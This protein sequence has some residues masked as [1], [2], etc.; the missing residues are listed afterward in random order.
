MCG[1]ARKADV[2]SPRPHGRS[3]ARADVRGAGAP[4]T[5]LARHA[6]TSGVGLGIQRCA[7]STSRPAT[8]RS[9]TRIARSWSS[10]TARSTTSASCVRDL[11]RAGHASGPQGDTEVIVHL[12]E[13]YGI[14]CV[15]HLHG[16]FAFALWDKRRA[17]PAA[18]PRPRRQ[19]AA[20]LLA[21]RRRAE[22]RLGAAARS[23]RIPRSRATLDPARARLLPAYGYVPAPLRD[24]PGG[25]ASCRRRTPWCWPTGGATIAR[26]WQLDY[27]PASSARHGPRELPR[28]D[29]RRDPGRDV[30]RRMIADVPLGA[31]LSGGIDS[32]AVVAAMAEASRTRSR[33]SRSA[34]STT[35]QRAA[36][37]PPGGRAVRH[38][39]PRVRGRAATRSTSCRRSSAT[40]ASRSPTPRRSRAST[41]PS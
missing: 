4:R 29:P 10:S 35:L 5:G 27:S 21:A 3:S 9:T 31:F 39:P 38:R 15:R 33:R 14:D 23:S 28:A 36:L 40:T 30:R 16:M 2:T 19:E 6:S 17:A 26:Y 34:S 32:S 8:S 7:W 25:V 37:R 41:S 22:L 11:Q 18:R 20:V 13:E 12:Y 24:L 1:I